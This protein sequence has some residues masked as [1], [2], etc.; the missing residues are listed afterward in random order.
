M[1]YSGESPQ[2]LVHSA[3]SMFYTGEWR[4]VEGQ[5]TV[6]DESGHIN[7]VLVVAEQEDRN[8]EDGGHC[9]DVL[10]DDK[11]GAEAFA[12]EKECT[13]KQS[14]EGVLEQTLEISLNDTPADS[15]LFDVLHSEVS[16]V[17]LRR[18]CCCVQ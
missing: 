12:P 13:W 3:L 5:E 15:Q 4:L 7:S 16:T 11:L 18:I 17:R 14:G 2:P 10:V 9:D 6:A 8:T 1:S